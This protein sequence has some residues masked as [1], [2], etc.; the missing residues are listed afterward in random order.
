MLIRVQIDVS[1]MESRRSSSGDHANVE[2]ALN[3]AC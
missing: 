3:Y 2:S 1:I